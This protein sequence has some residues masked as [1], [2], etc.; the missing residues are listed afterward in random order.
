MS[1]ERLFY[2]FG[3]SDLTK[4]Q[5]EARE[6]ELFGP[7]RPKSR[8]ELGDAATA[9]LVMVGGVVLIVGRVL[10]FGVPPTSPYYSP[11]V[12]AEREREIQRSIEALNQELVATKGEPVY[13]SF[14]AY[15]ADTFLFVRNSASRRP[16]VAF[17]VVVFAASILLA[18]GEAV[19]SRKAERSVKR[20]WITCLGRIAYLVVILGSGVLLFVELV[21]KGSRRP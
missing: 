6:L 8:F 5:L 17:F 20:W 12:K 4:Q 7:G 10:L 15:V 2:F 1:W 19:G 9:I 16:V 14:Y 13:H 18:I 21:L 11:D 3:L